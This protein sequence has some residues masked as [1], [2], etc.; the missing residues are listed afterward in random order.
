MSVV[1]IAFYILAIV[2]FVLAILAFTNP[3]IKKNKSEI[4]KLKA[5]TPD[6]YLEQHYK[7]T[8]L[9]I[10]VETAKNVL[11]GGTA[12]EGQS[13]F[14]ATSTGQRCYCTF[15]GQNISGYNPSSWP[16]AQKWALVNYNSTTNPCPVDGKVCQ[17]GIDNCKELC[18]GAI[19]RNCPSS[20]PNANIPKIPSQ[21]CPKVFGTVYK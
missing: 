4:A 9:D 18:A 17:A 20:Q 2:A 10:T 15:N 1:N 5:N 11:P 14:Q 19:T 6:K 7:N 8:P 3:Q 21:L 16:G 13:S 12:L